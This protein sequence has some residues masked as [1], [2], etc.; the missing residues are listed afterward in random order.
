LA[1]GFHAGWDWG[2]T[3]FYGVPDSGLKP[4]HNLLN[5]AFHGPAWLTGGSV[6]PEASVFTP[7]VLLIVAIL[8]SLAYRQ[9]RY[10]TQS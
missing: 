7:T 8:F 5:S 4:Y 3:F 9:N 10:T 2:Q 1:V 6:G